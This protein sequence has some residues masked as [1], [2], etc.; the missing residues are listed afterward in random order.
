MKLSLLVLLTVLFI[1]PALANNIVE[2]TA[3]VALKE[4]K[5]S[6][7]GT[8]HEH[9]GMIFQR[10]SESGP[11]VMFLEPTPEGQFDGVQVIDKKLLLPGDK[12]LGTYHLHLCM[13]GYYYDR[14]SA[15]DV[16]AAI[17]SGVPEF[18]LDECSG[19][20]HEFDVVGMKYKEIRETIR[21]TGKVSHVFGPNCEDVEKI[22]PVGQI[23]GNIGETEVEKVVKGDKVSTTN[24]CVKTKDELDEIVP[25]P[26]DKIQVEIAKK[27]PC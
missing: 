27:D 19:E 26:H 8:T 16:V 20:V 2:D 21:A 14:F 11:V 10:D 4:A 18:M 12:L 25:T 15:Q 24:P 13:K 23:V 7:T 5:H 1:Q 22:L 17:F 6:P 3:I 9:G